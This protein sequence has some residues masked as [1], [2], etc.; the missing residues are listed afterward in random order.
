[1][2]KES[3]VRSQIVEMGIADVEME[4][5]ELP[6]IKTKTRDILTLFFLSNTFSIL[7]SSKSFL[8]LSILKVRSIAHGIWLACVF[9]I[10]LLGS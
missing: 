10:S 4:R 3:F 6:N 1:M 7:D 5:A 9:V 2:E 8:E